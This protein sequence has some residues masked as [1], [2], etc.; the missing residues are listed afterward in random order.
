MRTRSATVVAAVLATVALVGCAGGVVPPL[1]T[2]GGEVSRGDGARS[3][4]AGP[5]PAQARCVEPSTGEE[6]DRVDPAEVGLDPAPLQEALDYAVAKGSQSVRVYRHGC[7]VGTGSNDASVGWVPLP[8]WSMTKGV[9]SMLVGRAVELGRLDVDDPIGEHLDVADPRKA[10]LTVRQL[11]NQTTGLRL[12]WASD[13]N[14]AATTDSAAAL[15]AR[16]FEAVP[17]TTFNYAQTTVTLLVA[18]VEAAVGEDLQSFA[19]RELFGPIGIA[20]DEWAWDRDGAGRSQGFAFLRMTPPAFG[21]LGRLL[22]QDGTWDGRRLLPSDYI[23]QGRRGTAANPC[24]GFLWRNNDGVGCR[25]TGPM[26]GLETDGNWMPTVPSDAY[27]LAGMFDQLVLVI[28]SLDMVVVRLGLP[29]QAFGD[30]WGDVGGERP[31]MTW[32]FFRTLMSAV[33]DVDVSDPG[34][35]VPKPPDEIDWAH[36]LEV[37]LPEPTW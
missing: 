29:P 1:A 12:A 37:P 17:G 20:A 35:W 5:A 25:Q 3:V 16:P 21:R 4:D 10:A 34:D 28:P 15:L 32:R 8:G 36:I 22:L 14:E 19:Q 24:Y 9:V 18:V 13:L 30:P 26:L 2:S 27:G 11:L 6:P 33:A 31:S 23:A 7:L